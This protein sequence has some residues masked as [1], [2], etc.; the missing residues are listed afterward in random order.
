MTST[1]QRIAYALGAIAESI[2]TDIHLAK[3]TRVDVRDLAL[4]GCLFGIAP[5]LVCAL[6][7]MLG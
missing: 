6:L 1:D 4:C 2:R 7:S 5:M 3:S